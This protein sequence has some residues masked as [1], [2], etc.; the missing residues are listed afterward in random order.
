MDGHALVH[1]DE[2]DE[3]SVLLGEG[4]TEVFGM[5]V[6]ETPTQ[7]GWYAD[8]GLSD[9]IYRYSPGGDGMWGMS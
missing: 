7:D 9:Y 3:K 1:R 5:F 6:R 2:H 4:I 8:A